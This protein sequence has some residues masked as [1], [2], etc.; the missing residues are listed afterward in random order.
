MNPWCSKCIRPCC[1]CSAHCWFIVP[2]ST[3]SL[4]DDSMGC[5]CSVHCKFSVP[6][7][8]LLQSP[9]CTCSVHCEFIG[10]TKHRYLVRDAVVASVRC[11]LGSVC[12]KALFGTTTPWLHLL[13]AL[14]V[15]WALFGFSPSGSVFRLHLL[16]ALLVHCADHQGT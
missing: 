2:V 9:C 12:H 10:P 6:M 15:H 13:G 3:C 16:G 8:T 1:T 5:T 14:L 7:R 4:G 11:T